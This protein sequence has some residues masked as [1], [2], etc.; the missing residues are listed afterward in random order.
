CTS[1]HRGSIAGDACGLCHFR[2]TRRI[3]ARYGTGIWSEIR[4]IE[5]VG[6]VATA[7]VFTSGFIRQAIPPNRMML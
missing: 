6:L 3:V 7:F 4:L 1:L 5:V 2:G